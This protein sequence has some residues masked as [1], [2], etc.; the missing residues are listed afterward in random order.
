[1]NRV[2][3]KVFCFQHLGSYNEWGGFGFSYACTWSSEERGEEGIRKRDE[4][5]V[6]FLS[7]C[8]GKP[9]FINPFSTAWRY[10]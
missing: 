4:G 9:V 8:F 3:R 7:F 1:M 5:Q 10:I 6:V 2:L